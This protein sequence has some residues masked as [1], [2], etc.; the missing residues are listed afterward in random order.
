[1]N[2]KRI[3]FMTLFFLLF[4]FFATPV[5]TIVEALE[6][7][8]ITTEVNEIETIIS[9][10][11][12]KIS[13][14]KLIDNFEETADL[15]AAVLVYED[16]VIKKETSFKGVE[17]NLKLG[18]LLSDLISDSNNT[19]LQTSYATNMPS[20]STIVDVDN[21]VDITYGDENTILLTS[22][23]V[24][25]LVVEQYLL[26]YKTDFTNL[27]TNYNTGIE[28]YKQTYNDTILDID[29]YI[30]DIDNKILAINT[31]VTDEEAL[32]NIPNLV[33]DDSNVIEL[34]NAQ[35]VLLQNKKG[36]LSL[37]NLSTQLEDINDINDEVIRVNGK[38]YSN[39]KNYIELEYD[40]EISNLTTNY[41][42]LDAGL[43]KFLT[44]NTLTGLTPV[45]NYLSLIDKD[46]IDLLKANLDYEKTYD[47][48]IEKLNEYLER[49]PSDKATIDG[50]LA[51]INLYRNSY[52]KDK[53]L[54]LITDISNNLDLTDEDK[55]DLLYPLLTNL[56][57]ITDLYKKIV[58]AKLDLYK[59]E[60]ID[61]TNY[62]MEITDTAI[63]LKGLFKTGLSNVNFKNNIDV[64]HS[65]GT[66]DIVSA[67]T[68]VTNNKTTFKLY[69]RNDLLLLELPVL[70]EGDINE[71]GLLD[72]K[73]ITALENNIKNSTIT[74]LLVGDLNKDELINITDLVLLENKI[75]ETGNTNTSKG[76]FDI[77]R[78][79]DTDA[80]IIS[81]DIVLKTDGVVKGFD[82]DLS[83]NSNL[84]YQGYL[85]TS[86]LIFDDVDNPRNIKGYDIYNDKDVIIKLIF[87]IKNNEVDS[88][89]DLSDITITFDNGNT[90]HIDKL[91]DTRTGIK[92]V[93]EES[94]EE[95]IVTAL[96]DEEIKKE[97]KTPVV[98]EEEKK[99][100]NKN[101]ANIIKII[102][103]VLLGVAIIYFLG[104]EESRS[105]DE[106]DF[107]EDSEK[108]DGNEAIKNEDK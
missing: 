95:V 2:K 60:L 91:S 101:I 3:A 7:T 98:V 30:L 80:M 12:A 65:E 47:E 82:F 26:S 76:N 89:I 64:L 85:G 70:I 36:S 33:V 68:L 6:P 57:N 66:H 29:D 4:N 102:V 25:T 40:D 73:D 69:D 81:Y 17:A 9:D 87:K 46:F 13:D 49:K 71:D 88:N 72:D 44:D 97:A 10:V 27:N 77:D 19:T 54:S 75:N 37:I 107:S 11:K 21:I 93:V 34:L 90:T 43:N 58:K 42:N 78:V 52:S 74:D 105:K 106:P 41:T 59:F 14:S 38:F 15:K 61:E 45:N 79:V 55:V 51:D 63:V 67:E 94:D 96:V 31:F 99:E 39:N 83:Y 16:E 50:L 1:M 20:D 8:N 108:D 86:N 103:I 48:L 56:D 92:P 53:V 84:E 18:V 22:D 24:K 35:K 104:K 5:M 32:G 28:N 23:E 62:Q 100:E